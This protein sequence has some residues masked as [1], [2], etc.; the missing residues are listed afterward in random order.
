MSSI[1]F[2]LL[3]P[4]ERE[5]KLH[6]IQ[7]EILEQKEKNPKTPKL[8]KWELWP[9]SILKLYKEKHISKDYTLYMLKVF[10]EWEFNNS[11]EE[12]KKY[13]KWR[14]KTGHYIYTDSLIKA[15]GILVSIEGLTKELEKYLEYLI[16]SLTWNKLRSEILILYSKLFP[17]NSKGFNI[18]T[19]IL[20][21]DE[22]FTNQMVY[23]NPNEIKN[24]ISKFI[25]DPQL[26]TT[27]EKNVKWPTKKKYLKD[28]FN[29]KKRQKI[30]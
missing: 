14:E 20:E 5:K 23:Y 15:I 11:P 6:Q 29:F 21:S 17:K 9:D 30:I 27:L 2:W 26:K 13:K 19:H 12:R 16:L 18:I 25:K 4:E 10:I 7:K 8:P 3:S 22:K 28:Y 1:D 24:N